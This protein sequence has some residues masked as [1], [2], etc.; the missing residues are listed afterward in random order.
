MLP[1]HGLVRALIDFLVP[2]LKLEAGKGTITP[3][4]TGGN[5][6]FLFKCEL[7]KKVFSVGDGFF[8]LL[9]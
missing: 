5:V 1:V 3:C 2:Q 9:R 7:S 6:R 8:P 4:N